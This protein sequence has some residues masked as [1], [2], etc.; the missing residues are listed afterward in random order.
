MEKLSNMQD[1]LKKDKDV[2]LE[3]V[4]NYVYAINYIND[5]FKDDKEVILEA[6]KYDGYSIE[7]AIKK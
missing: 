3:A 4:K 5:K 7:Y 1:R 6:V 2:A